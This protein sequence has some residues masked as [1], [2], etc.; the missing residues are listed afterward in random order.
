MKEGN[1]ILIIQAGTI[2]YINKSSATFSKM[3]LPSFKRVLLDGGYSS[4]GESSQH[5]HVLGPAVSITKLT[6]ISALPLEEHTW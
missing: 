1:T 2:G 4:E 5:A 6:C 3:F